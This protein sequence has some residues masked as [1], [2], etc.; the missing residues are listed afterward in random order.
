VSYE[1]RLELARLLLAD[2]DPTV[3]WI[4]AQPFQLV[5]RV[6]DDGPGTFRTSCWHTGRVAD[7]PPTREFTE[8]ARRLFGCP[9]WLSPSAW[10]QPFPRCLSGFTLTS[11]MPSTRIGWTYARGQQGTKCLDCMGKICLS[12]F[13]RVDPQIEAPVPGLPNGRIVDPSGFCDGHWHL[14]ARALFQPR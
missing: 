13:A 7:P 3:Q 11:T 10:T 6:M 4:Y 14:A 2:F 8:R 1:S 5:L 9:P 12:Q